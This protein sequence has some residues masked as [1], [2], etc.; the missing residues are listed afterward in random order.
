MIEIR[1]IGA[2][3]INE[4][5]CMFKEVFMNEPWNDDW[6]NEEQ[7]NKY[8]LDII[9]NPNSL[10]IGLYES[11]EMIGV[12]MGNIRHWYSGTEYY[13]DEF[14][15]KRSRQGSGK[16]TIFLNNIEQLLLK[17]GIKNIFLQT[18]RH[19][20]AYSFYKK[21]QFKELKDHVSFYK[22]LE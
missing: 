11:D 1:I 22:T 6:S 16:G 19:V 7:L 5:K 20:P 18:D 13:I 14:F 10:T 3:N 4:I 9:G 17:K 2:Q 8:I 15:M 12:S 21:N